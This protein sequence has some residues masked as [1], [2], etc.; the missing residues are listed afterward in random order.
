MTTLLCAARTAA[1]AEAPAVG[2]LSYDT[3]PLLLLVLPSRRRGAPPVLVDIILKAGLFLFSS[4][5]CDLCNIFCKRGKNCDRNRQPLQ[6]RKLA[7][8]QRYTTTR[9]VLVSRQRHLRA[10][11]SR[12]FLGFSCPFDTGDPLGRKRNLLTAIENGHITSFGLTS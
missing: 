1:A 12:R 11:L 10:T 2:Q 4:F 7:A 8:V 5:A 6:D 9:E 3:M